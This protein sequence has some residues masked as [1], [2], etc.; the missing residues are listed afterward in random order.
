VALRATVAYLFESISEVRQLTEP[1]LR[2]YNH[3][4]SH[5]S[6]EQV[7]P[8]V[9]NRLAMGLAAT[10]MP[11]QECQRRLMQQGDTFSTDS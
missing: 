8:L 6:L 2:T 11:R 1:W 10:L 3:E 5:D 7:P 9:W 4:R